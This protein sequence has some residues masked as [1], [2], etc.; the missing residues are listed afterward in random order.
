MSHLQ[1]REVPEEVHRT[2][3]ARAASSGRSLSE[4]VLLVL[5]REVAQ[6]TLDEVFERARRFGSVDAGDLIAEILRED[7]DRR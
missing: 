3:K 6:P 5:K 7:R 2:L 4:Y 1:V